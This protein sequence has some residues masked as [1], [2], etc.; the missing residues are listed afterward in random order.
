MREKHRDDRMFFAFSF[1]D[2]LE[3]VFAEKA[4]SAVRRTLLILVK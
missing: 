2:G 4:V 1:E 3:V